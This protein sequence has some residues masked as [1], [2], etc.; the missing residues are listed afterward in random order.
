MLSIMSKMARSLS[1]FTSLAKQLNKVKEIQQSRN[2]LDESNKERKSSGFS[3]QGKLV[4]ISAHQE[5]LAGDD[6]R[7]L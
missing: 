5:F 2:S 7:Y 4:L 6:D 3:K 1:N